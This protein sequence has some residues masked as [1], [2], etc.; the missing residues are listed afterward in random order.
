[1]ETIFSWITGAVKSGVPVGIIATG[2]LGAILIIVGI[3]V[4][5]YMMDS[6]KEILKGINNNTSNNA[7]VSSSLAE[8]AVS[9]G[10]ITFQLNNLTKVDERIPEGQAVIV[11]GLMMNDMFNGDIKACYKSANDWLNSKELDRNDEDVQIKIAERVEMSFQAIFKELDD[12]LRNFKYNNHYLNKY[13]DANFIN[14][15]DHV[16]DHVY[17]MLCEGTNGINAYIS[18][19]KSFFISDFNSY[20]RDNI[21]Q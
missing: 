9:L 7:M 10:A 18:T 4:I 21:N 8:V 16:K 13:M 14:E 17:G 20:L 11:Y 6:K 2:M 19:K 12:R 5:R 1:M 3:R 15:F